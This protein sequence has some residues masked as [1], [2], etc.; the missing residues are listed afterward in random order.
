MKK[1]ALELDTLLYSWGA[2]KLG[3]LGLHHDVQ[4]KFESGMLDHF[5]DLKDL[6]AAQDCYYR[7]GMLSDEIRELLTHSETGFRSMSKQKIGELIDMHQLCI[8]TPRPQVIVS[9]MGESIDEIY[10]GRDHV[11]LTTQDG[12]LYTWGS[13]CHGQLGVSVQ[14]TLREQRHQSFAFAHDG[15]FNGN[16]AAVPAQASGETTLKEQDEEAGNLEDSRPADVTH[17]DGFLKRQ[18]QTLHNSNMM[19]FSGVPMLMSNLN[20]KVVSVTCGDQ[21]TYCIFNI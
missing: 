15:E 18:L 3:K 17:L 5:Y 7:F 16:E 12:K 6:G 11:V 13:N 20:G 1:V 8:Y 21:N 10:T 2:A 9:L 4:A 14:S 19:S